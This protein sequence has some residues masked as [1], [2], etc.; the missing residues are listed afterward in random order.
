M[1]GDLSIAAV[2]VLCSIEAALIALLLLERRRRRSSNAE[3]L[4]HISEIERTESALRESEARYRAIVEDQTELIC[5]FLPDGTFTFVN[6]AYCNYFQRSPD[7]LLGKTFWEFIPPE[8]RPAAR[9]FLDSITP[10]HAVASREH[11]VL[12]PSGEIRWQ[13]WRDR[14]FFDDSGRVLEYQAVGRDITERKLAEESLRQLEAQ[15]QVEAALRETD[16]RKDEFLAMLAHQLRNPLA[17]MGT[18]VERARRDR[19]PA[20]PPHAPRR[21]FARRVPHHARQDQREVRAHRSA[22]GRDAG[23]RDEP[24]ADRGRR[25]RAFGRPAADRARRAW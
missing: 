20:D 1:A 25:P 21:R 7:T 13:Q 5:R 6:D 15:K 2:V 17:P 24:V 18:A 16:R 12:A 9:E 19:A 23:C 14:G 3:L 4:R 8:G 10:E 22:A 11:E